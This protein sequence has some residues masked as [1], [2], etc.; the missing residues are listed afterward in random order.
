MIFGVGVDMV[1]IERMR[2]SLANQHFVERVFSEEERAMLECAPNE[3]K[4]LE[5]AAANYAAKEAFLKAAGAG[6][7][8]FALDDI[9]ALRDAKGAP[10]YRLDGV[11]AD[12]CEQNGLRARLSL[13]HDGGM[14]VAFAVLE[15]E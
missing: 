15:K 14:A 10:Y 6:L 5:S 9:A 2:R 13:S 11:A 1:Q 7:G 3:N 8:G 4:R 12:F